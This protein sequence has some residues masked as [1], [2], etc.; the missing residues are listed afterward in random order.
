MVAEKFQIYGV[1][2]TGKHINTSVSQKIESAHFYSCPQAKLSLRC[3]SSRPG[4][5]KLPIPPEQHFLKIYFSQAESGGI[6]E[7]KNYQN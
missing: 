3:L 7:L 2:I 5:R 1:K 4:K 6:M